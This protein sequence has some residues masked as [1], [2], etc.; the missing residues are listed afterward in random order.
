MDH[1]FLGLC[2]YI[3]LGLLSCTKP[4]KDYT[5]PTEEEVRQRVLIGMSR[6]EVIK[7]F[8]PPVH[9]QREDQNGL[10]ILYYH[11]PLDVATSGEG[12]GYGGFEVLLK[13]GKVTE[14]LAI[15]REPS[16]SPKRK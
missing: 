16:Y 5:F 14:W 12:R 15:E 8:G 7:T 3:V 9:E 4:S 11:A 6:A 10:S 13:G 2:V 1:R